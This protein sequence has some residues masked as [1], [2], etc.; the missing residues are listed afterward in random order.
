MNISWGFARKIEYFPFRPRREY[1][2]K[3]EEKRE[4][5]QILIALQDWNEIFL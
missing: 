2:I 5:C 1:R 4:I 3:E